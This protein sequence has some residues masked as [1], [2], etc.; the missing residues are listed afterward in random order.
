M[1][2]EIDRE[3]SIQFDKE[4]RNRVEVEKLEQDVTRLEQENKALMES[5]EHLASMYDVITLL[6]E[7]KKKHTEGKE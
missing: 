6:A 1:S 2:K 5:K 4:R 3:Y 7:L